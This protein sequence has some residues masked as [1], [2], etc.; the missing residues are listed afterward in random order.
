MREKINNILGNKLIKGSDKAGHIYE[1]FAKRV[2]ESGSYKLA[3]LKMNKNSKNAL[4]PKHKVA[5][6]ITPVR[7]NYKG[8]VLPPNL[9]PPKE[10]RHSSNENY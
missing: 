10:K 5:R 2:N 8:H 6:K 3:S 9:L 4:W 7:L 1:T